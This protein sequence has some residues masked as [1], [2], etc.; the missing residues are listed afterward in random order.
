MLAPTKG[1]DLWVLMDVCTLANFLKSTFLEVCNFQMRL[2]NE[3]FRIGSVQLHYL[4]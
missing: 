1:I 2:L 4:V 3:Q